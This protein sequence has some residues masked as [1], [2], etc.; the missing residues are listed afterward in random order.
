MHLYKADHVCC[1]KIGK[2]INIKHSTHK[3]Y[4]FVK[5]SH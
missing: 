3:Q 2:K 4:I 5:F 1:K